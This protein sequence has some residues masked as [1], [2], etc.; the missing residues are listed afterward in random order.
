MSLKGLFRAHVY[1]NLIEIYTNN[2]YKYKKTNN[3]KN[4]AFLFVKS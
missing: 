2:L 1:I 3:S 4:I